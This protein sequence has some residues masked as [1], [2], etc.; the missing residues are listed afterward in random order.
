MI[1]L[2]SVLFNIAFYGWTTFICVVVM[3]FV[4]LLA[5]PVGVSIVG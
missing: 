4:I 3:P 5:K 2:G 1:W